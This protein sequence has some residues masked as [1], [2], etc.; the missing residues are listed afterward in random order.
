MSQR[1]R[2]AR[3]TLPTLRRGR[4]RPTRT[5]GVAAAGPDRIRIDLRI[6]GKRIRPTLRLAPTEAN[7]TQARQAR[8]FMVM[9]IKQGTFRLAEIFPEYAARHGLRVPATA[10]TCADVFDLFAHHLAAQAARHELTPETVEEYRRILNRC[11][12]P[13]LGPLPFLSITYSM[14]VKI[15][16]GGSWSAKTYN[17]AL[18]C[19]KG[20]F[21][22][23]ARDHAGYHNPAAAL[24]YA[25][26]KNKKG[27]EPFSIQDAE[28][29]IRALNADWGELQGN[30]DELRFFTGLRCCE[31][32][33]LRVS[34]YD[35]ANQLLNITK[36]RVRG[37]ERASTKNRRDR[38]V[39]LCARAVAAIER[40]LQ[41]RAQFVRRGWIDHDSLFFTERG[42]PI[43]SLAV[44]GRRWRATLTRLPIR[45]RTPYHARHTSV[46]WLLMVGENPAWVASQ[47]G[48]NELTMWTV[49]AA[50]AHG[51]RRDGVD[52]IRRARGAAHGS[53]ALD[54]AGHAEAMDG[55]KL[56]PAAGPAHG[57]VPEEGN[58]SDARDHAP[59]ASPAHGDATDG[60]DSVPAAGP[61]GSAGDERNIVPAAGVPAAGAAHGD[62]LERRDIAPAAGPHGSAEDERNIAPAAGVRSAGVG[63]ELVT[64]RRRPARKSLGKFTKRWRSGRDSTNPVS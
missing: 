3:H 40:Q 10:Q 1:T 16:D 42:A 43:R 34:D 58:V 35:R 7:L 19:V 45:Y 56:V 51:E 46:S 62:V 21:A 17:N 20:A 41:L 8:A 59:A 32:I 6:G 15:A 12:R 4:G 63:S 44:T 18:R 14:L 13:A 37:R 39:E 53:T 33:A 24:E 27:P 31:E 48:H 52:A 11:W 61:H 25:K 55:R 54:S 9:Q 26:N 60:R 47:H 38:S 23:G 64:A 28:T 2:R 49:Y 57:E 5:D 50:W 22:F 30:F 29:F 36:T